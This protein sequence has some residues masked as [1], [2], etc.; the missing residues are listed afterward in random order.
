MITS[1]EHLKK[2]S[3]FLITTS[4]AIIESGPISVQTRQFMKTKIG[5]QTKRTT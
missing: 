2:K 1:H 3:K 5:K 4:V